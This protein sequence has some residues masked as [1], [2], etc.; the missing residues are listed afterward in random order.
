MKRKLIIGVEILLILLTLMLIR[1]FTERSSKGETYIV[2]PIDIVIYDRFGFR[3][4]SL[5]EGTLT[6][7]FE[8]KII[9]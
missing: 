2:H 3:R 9:K 4:R 6:M 5:R 7:S 1:E 8:K